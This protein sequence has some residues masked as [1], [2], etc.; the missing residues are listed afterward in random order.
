MGTGG[1]GVTRVGVLEGEG[2]PVGI[3][4]GD[5]SDHRTRG[6]VLHHR[7]G[8]EREGSGGFLL[9]E[10]GKSE[11]GLNRCVVFVFGLH[12]DGVGRS[13]RFI[14]KSGCGSDNL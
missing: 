10:Q 1:V 11:G 4:G 6:S 13:I 14:V 7:I 12:A 3:R 9:V 8:G 2:V 5:L